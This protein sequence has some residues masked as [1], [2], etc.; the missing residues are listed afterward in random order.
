MHTPNV[1]ARWAMSDSISI[2]FKNL[3]DQNVVWSDIISGYKG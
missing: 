3:Q 1:Q 2:S